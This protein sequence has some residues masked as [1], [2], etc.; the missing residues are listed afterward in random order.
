MYFISRKIGNKKERAI[1]KE[2]KS[3]GFQV[4]WVRGRFSRYS[5]FEDDTEI[6]GNSVTKTALALTTKLFFDDG[7]V[8]ESV[9]VSLEAI[10]N[11]KKTNPHDTII[12]TL[13][14]ELAHV[15]QIREKSLILDEPDLFNKSHGIRFCEIYTDLICKYDVK[16][17]DFNYYIGELEQLPPEIEKRN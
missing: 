1:I 12:H 6:E 8:F 11:A 14:H 2:I 10:R 4:F 15:I 5:Q 9:V 13:I 7:D 17:I 3:Y 16:Y